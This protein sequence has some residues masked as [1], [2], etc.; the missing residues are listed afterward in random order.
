MAL[1]AKLST[2]NRKTVNNVLTVLSV[3]LKYGQKVGLV[4]RLPAF[5]RLRV[6]RDGEVRPDQL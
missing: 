5:D 2:H 6:A 4:E 1:K 3:L